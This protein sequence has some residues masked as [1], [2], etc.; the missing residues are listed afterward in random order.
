MLHLPLDAEGADIETFAQQLRSM[1]N[2]TLS[3]MV[4]AASTAKPR[5]GNVDCRNAGM[6][7]D[8]WLACAD[9][10]ECYKAKMQCDGGEPDCADG[11]DEAPAL[12]DP[13]AAP[14]A[15]VTIAAGAGAGA[16][17]GPAPDAGASDGNS[18]SVRALPGA[19][20]SLC[21]RRREGSGGG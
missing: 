7:G 16:G 18:D 4:A 14:P 19:P 5:Q 21:N 15:A 8:L 1:G 9:G 17:G 13:A 2:G 20:L 11:S 12:C 3:D 10:S 6:G